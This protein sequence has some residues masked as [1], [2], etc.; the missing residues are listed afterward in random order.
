MPD[1]AEITV[2]FALNASYLAQVAELRSGDFF[3]ES[4][5]M[6]RVKCNA[7]VKAME[8]LEVC[9]LPHIFPLC[10]HLMQVSA[11]APCTW[12]LFFPFLCMF[13]S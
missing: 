8:A 12:H 9:T 13:P 1:P 7:S 6:Y 2:S 3:G 5:C 4:S 11:S 10:P